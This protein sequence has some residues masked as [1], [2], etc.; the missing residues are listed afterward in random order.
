VLLNLSAAFDTVDH[1]ILLTV[2]SSRF[3]VA[4]TAYDWFESYLSGRT[5]SFCYNGQDTDG[6]P[7]NCSVLQ[8]SVLGPV[9]FAA[10]TEDIAELVE[11]HSVR[12]HLYADD[13][14]LYDHCR[15][16][17]VSTVRSIGSPAVSVKS[18]T[19]AHLAACNS[20]PIKRKS[21]GSAP[22]PTL[23]RYAHLTVHYPSAVREFSQYQ[24]FAISASF[25]TLNC[26]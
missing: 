8:G 7:V 6:F 21:F 14:Q 1:N 9:K 25:W 24:S 18:R 3:D 17:N 2:L 15:P 22:S 16:E 20:T 11:R 10:Y 23:P 5:Q 26:L 12:V 4:G 13:T 19:G